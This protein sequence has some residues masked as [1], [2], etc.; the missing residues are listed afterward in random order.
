MPT[1]IWRQC[2]TITKELIN[3]LTNTDVLTLACLLDCSKIRNTKNSSKLGPVGQRKEFRRCINFFDLCFPV[4]I[5]TV[6][7]DYRNWVLYCSLHSES[8]EHY[9][10]GGRWNCSFM[11]VLCDCGRIHSAGRRLS[12]LSH[13][14]KLIWN[15]IF[16]DFCCH[17]RHCFCSKIRKSRLLFMEDL[18][19][20]RTIRSLA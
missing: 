5:L 4:G 18:L 10:S 1:W 17:L 7:L 8:A 15:C 2:E 19:C 16:E 3:S 6:C 11:I 12:L 13:S 20:S 9:C 14:S